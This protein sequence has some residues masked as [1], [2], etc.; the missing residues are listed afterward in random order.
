MV[1]PTWNAADETEQFGPEGCLSIPG[2]R[3]DC[4]RFEHV[5]ASGWDLHGEPQTVEGTA[6]VARA[7][8]HETDHLDGVLFLDKLD[9]ETRARGDGRD[10]PGARGSTWRRRRRSGRA[11]TRSSARAT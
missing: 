7:I 10:P 1:N 5:V 9:P 4:R 8:Q 11:R 2:L 3:F 6:L